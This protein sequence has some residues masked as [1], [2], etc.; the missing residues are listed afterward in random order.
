MRS[1]SEIDNRVFEMGPGDHA[2]LYYDS[3]EEK[4]AALVPFF[5]NGLEN[6]ERCIYLADPDAARTAKAA[7]SRNGVDAEHEIRRGALVITS[8]RDYLSENRFDEDRMLQFLDLALTDALKM[9][10]SGL[11]GTG[12]MLWEVGTV[13]ELCKLRRYETALD[14]FFKGKRLIGL[15]Q[16]HRRHI[17]S[18]YLIDSLVH[19]RTVLFG[20]KPR[21][22]NPFYQR[23]MAWADQRT[24]SEGR[25]VF[26]RMCREAGLTSE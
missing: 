25:E 6:H 23:A 13:S 7:L 17:P 9:G 1:P 22:K 10:F 15:C 18:E 14:A 11:R 2:C 5:K 24:G 3:P 4:L 21:R 12:D 20:G 8:R 16:Y 26:D 19:H